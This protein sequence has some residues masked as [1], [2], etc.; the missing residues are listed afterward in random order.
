MDAYSV[1]ES[2]NISINRLKAGARTY[3]GG[4]YAIQLKK[5]R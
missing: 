5:N 3:R 4:E 2:G 1:G